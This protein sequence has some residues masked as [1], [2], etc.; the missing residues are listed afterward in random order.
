MDLP[1]P[2][3][4]SILSRLSPSSLCTVALVSQSLKQICYTD[5]IWEL[6]I[7]L[8]WGTLISHPGARRAWEFYTSMRNDLRSRGEGCFS[9]KDFLPFLRSEFSFGNQDIVKSVSDSC[10]MMK[11]YSALETGKFWLPAQVYNREVS[12]PL[13]SDWFGK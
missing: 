7:N 12:S 1:D 10:S 4:V 9:F 6:H 3:L 5:Q 8:K 11:Y 13:L 2:V